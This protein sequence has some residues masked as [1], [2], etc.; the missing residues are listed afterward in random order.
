MAWRVVRALMCLRLWLLV[1]ILS[2]VFY[3][4]CFPMPDQAYWGTPPSTPFSYYRH[5]SAIHYPSIVVL[6]S[7]SLLNIYAVSWP[8]VPGVARWLPLIIAS[9]A[10]VAVG[11][12]LAIALRT[13][14]TMVA[15]LPNVSLDVAV[16]AITVCLPASIRESLYLV[17]LIP[18]LFGR[19][20]ALDMTA[21]PWIAS[22]PVVVAGVLWW[23]HHYGPPST[24][25]IFP[26]AWRVRD[27][28]VRTWWWERCSWPRP[29]RITGLVSM[30]AWDA[31]PRLFIAAAL[32]VGAGLFHLLFVSDPTSG[33]PSRV[34]SFFLLVV[35]LFFIWPGMIPSFREIVHG[36]LRPVGRRGRVASTW[37]LV[38]LMVAT[39]FAGNVL[40]GWL[41]LGVPVSAALH[42]IVQLPTALVLV[43]VAA[44][45]HAHVSSVVLRVMVIVAVPILM[46]I[47]IVL[48]D[49]ISIPGWVG[50]LVASMGLL[51]S[52]WAFYRWMTLDG[53]TFVRRAEA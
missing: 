21:W 47:A 10:L 29:A 4:L 20:S 32:G 40:V 38:M 45:F 13:S 6:L 35:W 30:V 36:G 5:V 34:T 12:I 25:S 53:A 26:A 19:G 14:G 42:E 44:G 1:V 8:L 27:A 15:V 52:A 43:T 49:L 22:G 37:I 9:P 24:R 18:G 33:Q 48:I 3:A 23:R 28:Q 50:I 11:M 41:G 16:I 2:P 7:S 51:L 39:A 17:Y 46:V 31:F